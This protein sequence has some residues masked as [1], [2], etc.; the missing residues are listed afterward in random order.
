[1]VASFAAVAA[2][3]SR[4]VALR[5]RMTF[6]RSSDTMMAERNRPSNSQIFESEVARFI[7]WMLRGR[8]SIRLPSF[9][10]T[11]PELRMKILQPT[12]EAKK[13]IAR[14]IHPAP[15]KPVSVQGTPEAKQMEHLK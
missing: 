5:S 9:F 2:L 8:V 3:S 13:C 12:S 10:C 4:M 1:M 15:N 14:R 11:Y 6:S 7:V